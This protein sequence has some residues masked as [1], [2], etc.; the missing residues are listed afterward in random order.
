MNAHR[1]LTIEELIAGL[2]YVVDSLEEEIARRELA[3]GQDDNEESSSEGADHFA[4][5]FC[6]TMMTCFDSV[7]GCINDMRLTVCGWL[8]PW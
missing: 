6:V 4:W 5:P 1:E 7:G 8:H 2:Q 3:E